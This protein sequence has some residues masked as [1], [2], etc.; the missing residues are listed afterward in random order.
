[1]IFIWLVIAATY[2]EFQPDTSKEPSAV[3]ISKFKYLSGQPVTHLLDIFIYI[4]FGY[5]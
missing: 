2:S 4:F 1:M 3:L 5:I